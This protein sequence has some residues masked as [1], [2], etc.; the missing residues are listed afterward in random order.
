MTFLVAASSPISGKF[1]VKKYAGRGI[2]GADIP[3]TGDNG[4]SPVLNDGINPTSEYYWRVE[5]APSAGVLTIYPDLTFEFDATVVSDG[6]YPWVY[7]LFE[8]G[9][10]DGTATVNQTVVSPS[11][12]YSDATSGY[13]IKNSINADL[14]AAFNLLG[15]VQASGSA[16]YLLRGIAAGNDIESYLIRSSALADQA[17]AYLL[18]NAVTVDTAA[19]FSVCGAVAAESSIAYGIDNIGSVASINFT[20]YAVRVSVQ[21]DVVAGYSVRGSIS[22]GL[23]A[24]FSIRAPVSKEL[25]A[26]YNLSASIVAVSAELTSAYGIDG[27]SPACPTAA[28]IAAAIVAHSNTLTVQKFLGLK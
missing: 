22:T 18:R 21:A 4:G 27:I 26:A 25:S 7:R 24:E 12:V 17:A 6:S 10:D 2:L 11:V 3:T 16:S 13:L 14:A 19:N 8:D 23:Y 1:V 15:L 20:N 9:T 28:E 5:T